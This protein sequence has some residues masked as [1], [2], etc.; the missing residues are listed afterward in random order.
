MPSSSSIV[1]P[2]TIE[3]SPPASVCSVSSVQSLRSASTPKTNYSQSRGISNGKH[4]VSPTAT[5]LPFAESF[6]I[7]GFTAKALEAICFGILQ[8]FAPHFLENEDIECAEQLEL[9][10]A[11]KDLLHVS[12]VASLR[13]TLNGWLPDIRH[14]AVHRNKMTALAACKTLYEAARFANTMGYEEE[15]RQL[16]S[17][18]TEMDWCR[19]EMDKTE[20]KLHKD[21]PQPLKSIISQRLQGA[22]EAAEAGTEWKVQ[23]QWKISKEVLGYSVDDKIRENPWSDPMAWSTNRAPSGSKDASSKASCPWR[24]SNPE[25]EASWRQKPSS[26]EVQEQHSEQQKPKAYVPPNK[27]GG[28]KQWGRK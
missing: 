13:D 21:L 9:N 4:S 1:D 8:E 22:L 25:K 14:A 16:E 27:R 6:K 11:C 5:Q 2:N 7:I 10:R 24:S 17:I 20:A 28:I 26:D 12:A 19:A 18:A 3:A 23:D 15:G